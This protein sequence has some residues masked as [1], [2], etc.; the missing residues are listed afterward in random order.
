M[1][2][3]ILSEYYRS[4]LEQNNFIP[5][6][7]PERFSP[8]GRCWKIEPSVGSA[9]IGFTEKKTCTI[10]KSTIFIFMKSFI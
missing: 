1:K 7:S 4:L 10:S 5:I 8:A 6:P 9:S 3:D 2:K